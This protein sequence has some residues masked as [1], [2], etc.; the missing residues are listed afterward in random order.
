MRHVYSA[1]IVMVILFFAFVAAMVI[2]TQK[3]GK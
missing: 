2:F 3:D 1:H